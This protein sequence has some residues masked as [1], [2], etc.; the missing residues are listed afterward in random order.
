[1]SD[2]E[3]HNEKRQKER[4][5]ENTERISIHTNRAEKYILTPGEHI[6]QSRQ[7]EKERVSIFFHFRLKTHHTDVS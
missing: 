3:E 2:E 4:E 5:R 7:R 6:K 1:M